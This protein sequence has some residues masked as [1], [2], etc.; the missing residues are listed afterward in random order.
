MPSFEDGKQD[1]QMI[2]SLTLGITD[3]LKGS[4]RIL[5]KLS[6]SGHS[7]ESNIR[8][9]VQIGADS[10]HFFYYKKMQILMRGHDLASGLSLFLSQIASA[11]GCVAGCCVSFISQTFWYQ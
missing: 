9:N 1:Q 11:F 8:K 3:L 7:E 6:A 2:E 4:E 10:C 5:Q